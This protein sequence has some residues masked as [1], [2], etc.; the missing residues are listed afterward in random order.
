MVVVT[1]LLLAGPWVRRGK[2]LAE[3]GL[4]RRGGAPLAWRRARGTRLF[5][6]IRVSVPAQRFGFGG[7]G[8]GPVSVTLYLRTLS[9]VAAVATATRDRRHALRDE[10]E[11]TRSHLPSSIVPPPSTS[12]RSKSSP[13]DDAVHK[14]WGGLTT[15]Q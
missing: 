7:G 15:K 2:E 9:G 14:E 13:R 4:R 12:P 3:E 8:S 1:W 6:R 11:S 5:E 10:R